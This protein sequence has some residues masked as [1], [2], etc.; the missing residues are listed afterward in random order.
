MIKLVF[1]TAGINGYKLTI[2][3]ETKNY[4]KILTNS[5]HVSDEFLIQGL[6]HNTF[7]DFF[8]KRKIT[9][10]G[11]SINHVR[12]KRGQKKIT[13]YHKDGGDILR[14]QEF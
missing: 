1:K 6:P 2:T 3:S 13:K 4:N 10:L 5:I 11:S 12:L 14:Y 8:V 9:Y 7:S